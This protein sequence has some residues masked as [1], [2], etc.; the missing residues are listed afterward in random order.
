MK[1][2]NCLGPLSP[3]RLPGGRKKADSGPD[4]RLTRSR[5]PVRGGGALVR[6]PATLGRP[7]AG[8]RDPEA[9][10]HARV[11]LGGAVEPELMG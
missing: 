7:A 8:R 1:F 10:M 3:C 11:L 2:L 9:N 4:F 5:H 6:R